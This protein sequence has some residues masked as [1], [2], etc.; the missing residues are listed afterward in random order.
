MKTKTVMEDMSIYEAVE[1]LREQE[2]AL[3]VEYPK[4]PRL[5]DSTPSLEE[6]KEYSEKLAIFEEAE[7]QYKAIQEQNYKI[8]NLLRDVLVDKIKDE[9]GLND[10][11]KEYQDKVWSHAYDKGHGYGYGEVYN[12]LLDLVDIFDIK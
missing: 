10:I 8:I 9:S 7:K 4:R 6:S 1:Y 3:Y 5:K 12:Y 11:P 2:K